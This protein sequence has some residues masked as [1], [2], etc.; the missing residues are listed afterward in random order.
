MTD[1]VSADYVVVGAGSAGAVLAA[2]LS[3][4][5]AVE[6][7]LLEAGPDYR[8]AD[9]PPEMRSGH[10]S[11]LLDAERCPAYQWPRVIARRGPGRH[12]GPVWRGRGRRGSPSINGQA[13]I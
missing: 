11:G 3:E 4:D 8:S 5:P 2:R 9:A 13:T 7:V 10:W 6:V 1:P 12:P